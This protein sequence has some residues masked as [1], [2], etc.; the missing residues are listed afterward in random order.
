M[1]LGMSVGLGPGDVMLDGIAAPPKRGTPPVFGPCLSWPNGWMGEDAL[2]AE[3]DIGP[4]HIAL[5]GPSPPPAKAAQQTPALF[6][7]CLLWPRSPISATA[8]LLLKVNTVNCY[9]K[10]FTSYS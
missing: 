1:P 5:H 8:E 9:G 4:G 10:F 2:N 3:V 7:P 6:G